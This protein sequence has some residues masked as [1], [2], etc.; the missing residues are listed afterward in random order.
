[1]NIFDTSY[2]L[3]I[4]GMTN[5]MEDSAT[6]EKKQ[7]LRYRIVARHGKWNV[8]VEHYVFVEHVFVVHR[9]KYAESDKTSDST[10]ETQSL[11]IPIMG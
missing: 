2:L 3:S 7:R 8:F 4:G 6:G 1:M 5:R 9:A 10:T 11:E